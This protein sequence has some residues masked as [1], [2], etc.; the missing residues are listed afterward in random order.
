MPRRYLLPEF[1]T[2]MM[3][4][5]SPVGGQ[6]T[7]DI[8]LSEN[9]VAITT[10]FVGS[11]LLLFGATEGP[12]D[13][14]V[15]VRGPLVDTMVRRKER[16][17]GVWV[18]R[19]EMLFRDVPDFYAVASNRPMDEFLS[20]ESRHAFQ[21]GIEYLDLEP[22][23]NTTTNHETSE[24]R[25]ALIRNKQRRSLYQAQPGI[26]QFVGSRLFRTRIHFPAN[27][28]VGTYGVDVYLFQDNRPS[29][30]R[31]T[32]INVRKFGAEASIYDFAHRH[33]L[34]YGVLAVLIA[35]VA[36]WLANMVFRR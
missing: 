18:N 20:R 9:V 11:S 33:S 25:A 5:A 14:V 26:V 30:V 34:A 3:L 35:I 36:G 23:K 7:L 17:V 1:L 27:V 12:G 29:D 4:F 6:E 2:A 21:L 32:L 19:A 15:V 16:V 10:G 8:D 24:F 31:T 13:I 22:E 28:A